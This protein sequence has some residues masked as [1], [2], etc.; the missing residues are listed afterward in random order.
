MSTRTS[1]VSVWRA[2]LFL[3]VQISSTLDR[4]KSYLFYSR[5]LSGVLRG[6]VFPLKLTPLI[7]VQPNLVAPLICWC[8]VPLWW[9]FNH[10]KAESTLCLFA[11]MFQ[12]YFFSTCVAHVPHK[13]DH[14]CWLPWKLVTYLYQV[15]R[16]YNTLATQ[17]IVT[18]SEVEH[19]REWYCTHQQQ[20]GSLRY[21][22]QEVYLAYCNRPFDYRCCCV[23]MFIY[24]D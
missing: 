15:L 2:S 13:R 8:F 17:P 11:F 6:V 23:W 20:V 10:C 19:W 12:A 4:W 3:T 9:N 16:K 21:W 7:C 22:C 14:C 5:D 18:I 1:S 24:C